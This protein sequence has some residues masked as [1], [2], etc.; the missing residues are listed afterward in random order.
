MIE[1]RHYINLQSAIKYACRMQKL[2][3]PCALWRYKE[4]NYYV[5][6]IEDEK[7]KTIIPATRKWYPYR[8]TIYEPGSEPYDIKEMYH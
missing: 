5:C 8:C 2:G 6:S 4:A 7:G 1:P 3:Y